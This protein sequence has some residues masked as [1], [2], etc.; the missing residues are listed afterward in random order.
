[1]NSVAIGHGLGHR[2]AS[3]I[4]AGTRTVFNDDQMASD[5]FELHAQH[6]SDDVGRATWGNP[7][8]IVTGRLGQS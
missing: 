2:R 1:M 8:I 3:D 5:L 4:A 6:A 7:M